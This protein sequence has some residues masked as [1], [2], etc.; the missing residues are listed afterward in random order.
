MGA[1]LLFLGSQSCDRYS[2]AGLGRYE[3]NLALLQPGALR[4][5]R[6]ALGDRELVVGCSRKG[7]L[8]RILQERSSLT[9]R[10]AAGSCVDPTLEDRDLASAGAGCAALLGG[11]RVLRVHNVRATKMVSDAFSVI[12]L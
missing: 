9:G 6:E 2:L 11:A 3:E 7:F 8:T 5:L 10:S 4:R 12:A 1:I